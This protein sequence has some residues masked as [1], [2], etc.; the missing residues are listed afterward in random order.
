[1]KTISASNCRREKTT[2]KMILRFFCRC[3]FSHSLGHKPTY[4]PQQNPF[5][6][7]HLVGAREQRRR[8]VETE[9]P[10]G[11]ETDNQ[12]KSCRLLN[13]EVARLSSF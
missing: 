4:A 9:R 8:H 5:L 3:D 2:K 1:L 13:W 10:G 11:L 7:D 6:F 12:L